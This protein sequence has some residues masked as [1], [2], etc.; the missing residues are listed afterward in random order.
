[1]GASAD[2][3]RACGESARYHICKQYELCV[4]HVTFVFVFVVFFSQECAGEEDVQAVR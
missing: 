1:M 2:N 4:W 3:K